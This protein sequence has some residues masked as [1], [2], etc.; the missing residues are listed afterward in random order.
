ME[1]QGNVALV[2]GGASGLGEATV[3]HLHA[4]GAAVVIFDRNAER[5]QDIAD[6]LGKDAVFAAGSVLSEADTVAAVEAAAELGPLRV[7]VACAG[8]GVGKAGRLV[9]RD[10]TPHELDSFT[11]TVELNLIGAF[12]SMRIAAAQMAKNEPVADGERGI[13]VTTASIAGFEGQIGQIAYSSA[14]AGIIGMTLTAARDLSAIGVRVNSIA[15]GMFDTPA[16][17]QA[18]SEVKETLEA[19]I[20]FPHRF[21]KPEE[22]AALVEHMITNGYLNG[23]VIRLDGAIRFDP[24]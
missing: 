12:N 22:F 3:R 17:S 9:G 11:K 14:K 8:G 19:K 23:Q 10:G 13:V 6:E 20:P 4:K 5:G 1:I 15:P 21:G 24:K 7:L 16:W 18:S 2:T